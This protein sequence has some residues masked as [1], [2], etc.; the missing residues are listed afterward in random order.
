MRFSIEGHGSSVL[1]VSTRRVIEAYIDLL[2]GTEMAT[3]KR[4]NCE[5]NRRNQQLT[6]IRTMIFFGCILWEARKS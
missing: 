6:A 2:A 1:I 5:A 4:L 3:E